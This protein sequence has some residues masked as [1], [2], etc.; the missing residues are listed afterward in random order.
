MERRFSKQREAIL[1]VLGSTASH[2]TADRIY[3]LVRKEIPGIRTYVC[4]DGG[5]GD[6]IRP[7]LYDAGYEALLA[8]KPLEPDSIPVTIAGKYCE[9]GD[10]LIKDIKMPH[11]DSGDIIAIPVSGAYCIPMSSNYNMVPRPPVILVKD[12]KSEVIRKR[13]TYSDLK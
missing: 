6:N 9:S 13:E 12:G 8:N 2:P 4:V 7:A 10:I 5:M 1:K 11:I 3:D